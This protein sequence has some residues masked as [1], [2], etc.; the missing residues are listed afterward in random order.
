MLKTVVYL[1]YYVENNLAKINNKR[2]V[3]C[4][5]FNEIRE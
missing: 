1:L 2:V 3:F 5:T 4:S